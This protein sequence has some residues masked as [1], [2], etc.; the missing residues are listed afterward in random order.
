VL[1]LG[2]SPKRPGFVGEPPPDVYVAP[3]TPAQA[4]A[5]DAARVPEADVK[6]DASTPPRLRLVGDDRY[7]CTGHP[8]CQTPSPPDGTLRVPVRIHE[9]IDPS[10]VTETEGFM[11]SH[12]IFEGL[13]NYPMR[14]GASEPGVAQRY[15][16]AADQR[17]YTFHLR[18]DARW[19]NGR[20]VTAHDFVYAWLR[21][22]DPATGSA[23]AD[24]LH[25]LQGGKAY[26]EGKLHDPAGV[27]V[28]ATDDRT[29]QVVLEQ[30]TPW[31][32]FLVR[33]SHYAPVPREAVEAHGRDW[34]RPEHIV[35]NGAY[36]LAKWD[37]RAVSVLTRS[38]TYWGRASV[39][40]PKLE[41]VYSDSLEGDWNLYSAG[42]VQWLRTSLTPDKIDQLLGERRPDFT[43]DP[44]LCV[45][46][47]SFRQDRPPFD[48]PLVRRAFVAGIDKERLV[49]HVVRGG[50]TPAD[51]LV[52]AIL[53][54]SAGMPALETVD[55]DPSRARQ[56]LA[57]AGYPNG[58][59]LPG[60]TLTYNTDEG[61]RMIAEFVQRSVK[62]NLGIEI[63]LEN[64]EWKSMLK[65]LRTGDY[66]LARFGWC[67]VSDPHE[68]LKILRSDSPHNNGGHKSAKL[69]QILDADL[70]ATQASE[71]RH[72]WAEA[73]RLIL[74]EA[75]ILP[76]YHYA[77]PILKWPVLR[78]FD[79]VL[80]ET[81]L[82]KY[83]Y[84]GD[85]EGSSP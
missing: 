13:L 26:N 78:G 76:L 25:Y 49:K 33:T 29:L 1:L 71:R 83:M 50:R 58:V 34:T 45:Y 30:P 48:N 55:F 19:S 65:R 46:F 5:V 23:S 15:E 32:L 28:R 85:K 35:T 12:N 17:T 66:Q 8:I 10:L 27:G 41:L 53:R 54:R 42:Q 68:F 72:A 18:P 31:W 9:F 44:R 36:H 63:T 24:H 57:E 7:P 40:I 82:F 84:W 39:K 22:L 64:M 70:R 52:P 14:E 51:T 81:H 3:E 67:G 21:K 75:P 73:E 37:P 11:I 61:H 20:L 80:E 4:S 69:D 56:L 60:I 79:T 2:C 62:E 16:L 47:Y 74:E 77:Q 6:S 59:G 38:D 43:I